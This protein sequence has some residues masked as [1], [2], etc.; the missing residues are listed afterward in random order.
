MHLHLTFP[1]PG[2]DAAA[3]PAWTIKD[4]PEN[5]RA[6]LRPSTGSLPALVITYGPI[7]LRPDEP[8]PWMDQVTRADAP[9]DA[10]VT[11][12]RTLERRTAVGWPFT[13]IEAEVVDAAGA[14]LEVRLC[15][16]FTFMEHASV[17]IVRAADRAAMEAHGKTVLTILDTARP[18]WR[19][20][21]VCLAET[22]DLAAPGKSPEAPPSRLTAPVR[23][24]AALVAALA[25]IDAGLA[26]A[27]TATAHARRGQVLLQLARPDEALD[28]LRAALALEPT[29][30]TAH[31]FAGVALGELGHHD[32]AIAAW[33]RALELVPDRVDTLYNLAQAQFLT[34]AFARALDGFHAVARLDPDDFLITRKIIQCLYALGRHD[35]GAALRGRFRQQWS[36]TPDPRARFISE[37]VFDQFEADGFWVHALETLRPRNPAVYPLM[38][39]RAVAIHGDHDHPLPATVTIET[40]DQAKRADTPFVVGVKAGRQYRVIHPARELP[41]YPTLKADVVRLLTDALRASSPH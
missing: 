29:L 31:Y 1:I 14:T 28:A 8:G 4:A 9:R 38:T 30:E 35:D 20:G 6:A 37:Y 40:S 10:R 2:P 27:P 21:P 19:G 5:Q 13:L 36:T 34:K 41:P 11:I 26:P 22:W 32:Q 24:D 3:S 39:F 25:A 16:F 18:D 33:E 23:D 7:I 12:G 15:A 17:A